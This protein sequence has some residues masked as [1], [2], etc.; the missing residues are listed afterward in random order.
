MILLVDVFSAFVDKG[1]YFFN[2]TSI[3]SSVER[4]GAL[5]RFKRDEVLLQVDDILV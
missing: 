4:C 3:A 1:L 2:V 5:L